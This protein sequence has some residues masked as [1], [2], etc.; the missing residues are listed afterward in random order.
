MNWLASETSSL[1][2][3]QI[4]ILIKL[5]ISNVVIAWDNDVTVK[6]IR[7]EVK[8]LKR[9]VNVYMIQDTKKLLGEPEEKVS[10][11]DKGRAVWEQ[12]Y[13]NKVRIT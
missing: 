9:F 10:P 1:N 11:P 6:H 13:N 4:I 7:A 12:L 5:G 3:E 2:M 8:E